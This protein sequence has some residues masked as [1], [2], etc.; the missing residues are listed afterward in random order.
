MT[1]EMFT[2]DY[3]EQRYRSRGAL[4]SGRPNAHLVS[5]VAG[6]EPGAAL[7]VGCG[8]GADAIWLARR[9]WRV[10]GADISPT[11]LERAAEHARAAGV[12]ATWVRADVLSWVPEPGRYDLVTAG[13]VHVP[14][15]LREPLFARLA[16]AVAPGGTLLIAG[17]HPSDVGVVP[18]PDVP[19]LFFTADELAAAL[20]PGAWE[21]Q[22]AD[23]RPRTVAHPEHG[24]E[25]TIHDAVLRA[26]R[27]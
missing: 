18:R 7:D 1:I 13:F 9:G 12:E 10:T 16:E 27:R 4:W 21:V 6:L 23:A 25:V 8:E 20:D 19:E 3:W 22:A 5:D 24:G 17:H 11:A 15:G 2:E 14:A 26:R